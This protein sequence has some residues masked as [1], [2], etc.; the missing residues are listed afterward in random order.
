MAMLSSLQVLGAS[1]LVRESVGTDYSPPLAAP[2]LQRSSTE[3]LG[4]WQAQYVKRMEN[5]DPNTPHVIPPNVVNQQPVPHQN[6]P[7]QFPDE[8]QGVA[9]VNLP[10]GWLNGYENPDGETGVDSDV[11][12]LDPGWYIIHIRWTRTPQRAG[13][14]ANVN[15][16]DMGD[17]YDP[18]PWHTIFFPGTRIPYTVNAPFPHGSQFFLDL[19]RQRIASDPPDVDLPNDAA[20]IWWVERAP[21]ADTGAAAS[22]SGAVRRRPL[23]V[24]EGVEPPSQRA[25]LNP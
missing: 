25:R 12:W 18:E 1:M 3:D 6:P 10:C 11:F 8:N 5:I 19:T 9:G 20:V 4:V 17:E 15:L 21:D 13:V 22:G 24:D 2:N 23:P 7:N 16:I 14:Q